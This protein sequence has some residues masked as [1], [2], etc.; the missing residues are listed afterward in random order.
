MRSY[1]ASVAYSAGIGF[2]HRQLIGQAATRRS[3]ADLHFRRRRSADQ[4]TQIDLPLGRF[5]IG[6]LVADWRTRLRF[7][8]L[9]RPAGAHI[10]A[11]RRA[12]HRSF[13]VPGGCGSRCGRCC[14]RRRRHGRRS[15]RRFARFRRRF[16]LL[17]RGQRFSQR[18]R[19][20]RSVF[21][22]IKRKIGSNDHIRPEF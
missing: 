4:F 18:F 8:I 5:E 22:A 19:R 17:G 3:D 11:S 7:R 14:R 21:H 15:L 9:F 2:L 16:H 13:H 1:S 12:D 10:G 6:A 20:F